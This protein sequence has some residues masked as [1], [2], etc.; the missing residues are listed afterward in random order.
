ML[1]KVPANEIFKYTID[2]IM[3]FGAGFG[4]WVL[5]ETRN[6]NSIMQNRKL[7]MRKDKEV[8]IYNCDDIKLSQTTLNMLL[9]TNLGTTVN[10]NDNWKITY[11]TELYFNNWLDYKFSIK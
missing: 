7:F 5:V 8:P 10:S 6:E 4:K 3:N 11:N 1:I 2:P 9:G